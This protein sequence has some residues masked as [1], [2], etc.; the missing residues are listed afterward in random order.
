VLGQRE[1]AKLITKASDAYSKTLFMTA[2]LIAAQ[3]GELLALQWSDIDYEKSTIATMAQLEEG[4]RAPR[5]GAPKSR[6][7]LRMISIQPKLLGSLGQWAH[8]CPRLSGAFP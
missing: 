4:R 5:F 7:G 8:E 2:Y 6:A 3:E 1:I